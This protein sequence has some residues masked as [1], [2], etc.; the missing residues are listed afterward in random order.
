MRLIYLVDILVILGTK[1]KALIVIL[2]KLLNVM[3]DLGQHYQLALVSSRINNS[4]VE[5]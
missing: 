3:V 4:T 5:Y 2:L 1:F